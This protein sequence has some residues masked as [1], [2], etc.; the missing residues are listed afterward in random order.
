MVKSAASK[1]GQIIGNYFEQVV[2]ILLEQHLAD[3]HPD[4]ILLGTKGG[5]KNIELEMVGGLSWQMD[6]V[7]A[8]KL[9]SVP[10]ALVETKWLKDARHHNDKGAWILQLRE[11]RKRYATIRGAVTALSGYW[12]EGVGLMLMS[13]GGIR[14][15]FV[16]TDVQVYSTLQKPLDSFLGDES[17]VLDAPTMRRSYSHPE[18][19]LSLLE[20]LEETQELPQIAASWLNFEQGHT[21]D[22]VSITGADLV[23]AAI[24]DLLAPL[25]TN[26]AIGRL[27]ISLQV[28]TGNTI[29]AEFT[30]VE[31]ALDLI[32]HYF[33]NPRAILDRIKPRPEKGVHSQGDEPDTA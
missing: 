2:F 26:P 12:T 9:S 32:Q 6:N 25:P 29:Y 4:Y 10:V 18:K 13:E 17:F 11:V 23:K 31:E 21:E 7:I 28:D 30:D 5:P 22:G 33:A 14:M 20:Y 16:A 1:F 24:D 3:S 27:E 19:L 15:V 8:D